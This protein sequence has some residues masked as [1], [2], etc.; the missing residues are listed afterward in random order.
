MANSF[1]KREEN[2]L[3]EKSEELERFFSTV[4]DLLCIADTEGYF[5]RLN[6]EWEKTL[7]YRLEDLEGKRFLDLVHPDD[8]TATLEKIKDLSA[9]KSVINFANRY[10]RKDG[11][12]RW[13][14]WRSVS[15]G[16]LIYSAARDITD[17]KRYEDA[18][19]LSEKRF[20]EILENAPAGMFQSTPGGKFLY[21]N[22]V[23]SVMLGYDSPEELIDKVNATSIAEALYEDPA[24][25]P[26]LVQEVEKGAGN[27][28]FF[29]NRYRRK[30][31][32]IIDAILSFCQREDIL[33]GKPCL[34]GFVQDVT[35][36]K[37]TEEELQKA[38]KLE[39]LG[40]LA[41]GI[42]HDFNNLLGGI[43]GYIDIAAE[44]SKDA[45]VAGNLAKALSTIDRARA[46]TGQLLTFAKGG[47]PVKKL[48]RLGPFIRETSKVAL[49]GLNARCTFSIAE[50][51][52][53]CE[54]DKNQIGQV[55][56]N[57]VVNA[58]QAV[59]AGGMIEISAENLHFTERSHATLPGGC[60]IKIAIVDHGIGIPKEILP[61]IFDPFFT[62]KP[63]GHGLG[64]ATCYSIIK[65]HGGCVDVESEPGKGS[66]FTCYLPAIPEHA[67]CDASGTA[68]IL[69]ESGSILVMDDEEVI[70]DAFRSMLD[71]IG[72][73]AHC[74]SNSKEALAAIESRNKDPF[75]A[76]ILDLT[77]PGGA[78]G[79]ETIRKIRMMG[80]TVPALVAS[81]YADD[82]VMANPEAYGF[83]GS[84]CKPFRK[85][86]LAELL[87]RH[88]KKER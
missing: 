47:A 24:R 54:F 11:T 61:K 84:I 69:H 15:D 3:P 80:N 43:F 30:D 56:H 82:P 67:A 19:E 35:D 5:R 65:R 85:A 58:Q 73:G 42:A 68:P 39:S 62:T 20:R 36:R 8:Q 51:L 59:P 71:S 87:N 81:G 7:G 2:E 10:R 1:H 23:L 86:E 12:Y 64:L 9:Q 22:P 45:G 50:D 53:P 55:I 79:K 13:I 57:I 70:R 75:I 48:D 76:L 77:I 74:V 6:P 4:I 38:H 27:W 29:E 41:G 33:T 18:I 78:G 31:G 66:A 25:R 63:K 34:Y 16:K 28:K 60:Y 17:R 88:L 52:W 83:N 14:E 32:R 46:L 21:V 44:E 40:I 49:G 26:V 37:R 72:Y